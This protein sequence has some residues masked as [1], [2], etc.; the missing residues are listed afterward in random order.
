[1]E[2]IGIYW[3]ILE[4]SWNILEA[5]WNVLEYIALEA[6][7][8]RSKVAATAQVAKSPKV[9]S[10]ELRDRSSIPDVVQNIN[11]VFFLCLNISTANFFG[12]SLIFY[13]NP[14]PSL[15]RVSQKMSWGCQKVYILATVLESLGKA[16]VVLNYKADDSKTYYCQ[17]TWQTLEHI[18]LFYK[19]F[20]SACENFIKQKPKNICIRENGKCYIFVITRFSFW[21]HSGDQVSV[22]FLKLTV[23]APPSLQINFRTFILFFLHFVF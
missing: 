7:C 23:S 12:G 2:H 19:L 9:P 18:H 6:S 14:F 4:A 17:E 21:K 22:A 11:F 5:S 3:N 20:T 16:V 10:N 13:F 1:M 15:W 8:R